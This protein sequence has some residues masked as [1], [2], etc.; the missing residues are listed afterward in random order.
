MRDKT[1][2]KLIGLSLGPGDPMLITR[3]AW[4]YLHTDALWTYPVK[5]SGAKSFALNIVTR[6]GLKTPGD[7]VALVFPMTYDKKILA[8]CWAEASSIV[9]K[10]LDS[11]RDV[12]FLVEG[13]ASTYATFGH[14][15]GTIREKIPAVEVI[16]I[17]GV[18][19]FAACA[20]AT[21]LPLADVDDRLAILP[22][23]YGIETIERMLGDFDT[24]VLLKVKPMIDQ[25]IELLKRCDLMRSSY[26]VERVGTP[27]ERIVTDLTALPDE[28]P[29]Y[30]SLMII[31]NPDRG[32]GEQ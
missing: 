25:V 19:S 13:D 4:D 16:T 24:L 23:G 21:G 17:A 26:F 6:A 10:I 27:E 11:G 1:T 12:L 7:A 2:G 18:T 30:L 3:R 8:A 5:K 22:A 15:A 9:I 20:A 28:K 32:K 29:N 31:H 14:L